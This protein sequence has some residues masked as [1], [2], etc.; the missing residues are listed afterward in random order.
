M[1]EKP[2][3]PK[4]KSEIHPQASICPHCRTKLKMSIF[5]KIFA[6][7]FVLVVFITIKNF[8]LR[9]TMK[10]SGPEVKSSVEPKVTDAEVARLLA[11]K[12]FSWRYSSSSDSMSGKELK[13][14]TIIS[15]N[16]HELK[17]PYN[18]GT[19]GRVM[20]RKHP[21]LG[22]S[23]LFYVNKGYIQC[24]SYDGCNVTIKFDD[25]PPISVKAYS[26]ADNDNTTLFLNGYKNLLKSLKKA[27]VTRIEA[28]FYQ[29]GLRMFEFETANLNWD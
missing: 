16:S 3:C 12:P 6:G 2:L 13:T 27:S 25:A 11:I 1:S 26:P 7:F 18:G 22:T 29:E 8:V 5:G 15:K 28:P 20:I 17:F 24:T 10:A 23:I 4:C 14:A 21:R 9:N 19:S